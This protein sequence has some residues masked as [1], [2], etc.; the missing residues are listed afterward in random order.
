MRRDPPAPHSKSF[1]KSLEEPREFEVHLPSFST[2]ERVPLSRA[3]SSKVHTLSSNLN[4]D[5]SYT[6]DIV[7]TRLAEN[8]V[9]LV[10]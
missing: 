6:R 7:K 4:K 10:P 1:K 9:A 3:K 5:L 2:E 8:L